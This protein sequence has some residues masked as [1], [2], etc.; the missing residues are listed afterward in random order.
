MLRIQGL[1][2]TA[3]ICSDYTRSK[4]FYTEVLGLAIIRETHRPERGSF[5]LDLAGPGFVIELFSFP[6]PPAR[7]THPEACG[8][9]HLALAVDDLN[10]AIAELA[11]HGVPCEPVRIDPQTGS[12]FTF[13]MDPDAMPIELYEQHTVD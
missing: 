12:P 7:V 4:H 13:F 2:H 6:N 5:K 11:T 3:I 8:L 1:H 9:R 10:A